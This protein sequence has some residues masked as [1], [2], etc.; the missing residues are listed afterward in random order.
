M[1]IIRRPLDDVGTADCGL[2]SVDLERIQSLQPKDGVIEIALA[3]AIIEAAVG[4]LLPEQKA[5]DQ[6]GRFAE[7]LGGQP[8]HLEHLQPQAHVSATRAW[9]GTRVGELTLPRFP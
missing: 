1:Q 6:S 8:R 2:W 3:A 4:V 9:A 5:A 7:K